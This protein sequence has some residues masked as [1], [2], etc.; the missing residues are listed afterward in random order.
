MSGA[1]AKR[2]DIVC[3]LTTGAT[4]VCEGSSQ[5]GRVFVEPLEEPR[6]P[7]VKWERTNI[8]VIQ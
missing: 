2:G 3:N 6:W 4:G 7:L 1:D 5:W 8:E